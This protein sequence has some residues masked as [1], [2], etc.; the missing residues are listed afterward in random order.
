[1]SLGCTYDEV[2]SD[3]GGSWLVVGMIPIYNHKSAT[4]AGRPNAGH[5]GCT[6]TRWL[7]I[8][9]KMLYV[10]EPEPRVWIVPITSILGRLP[11]VPVGDTG[12]IP[13]SMASKQHACFPEGTCDRANAPGS[14]SKLFYTTRGPRGPWSG[15][16]GHG[17]AIRSSHIG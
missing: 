17:L 16:V 9:T 10:P 12:T 2:R 1:V 3:P 6:R 13:F 14:G 15:H 7:Y 4:R 11:L 5:A 8:G